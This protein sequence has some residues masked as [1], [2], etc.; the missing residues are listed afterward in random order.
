MEQAKQA[1]KI[2]SDTN[3]DTPIEEFG[4]KILTNLGWKEGFGLGKDSDK[5]S[6]PI[7]YI[8]R[9]HRLGLGAKALTLEQVTDKR[10]KTV[11][12]NY[13][14]SS[15]GKNYKRVGEQLTI[16]KE[17]SV[18]SSVE[19]VSGTHEGLKGEVIAMKK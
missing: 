2:G 14:Q 3:F 6:A 19:I 18:G 1:L 12:E 10:Q 11:T 13:E 8:P 5:P 17:I 7:E 9:Q 15:I 4:A 16:K